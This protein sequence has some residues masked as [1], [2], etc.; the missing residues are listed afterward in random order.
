[1]REHIA[2]MME[3]ACIPDTDWKRVAAAFVVAC[4]V[5]SIDDDLRSALD[6]V[7]RLDPANSDMYRQARR[8]I[9]SATATREGVS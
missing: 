9:D 4:K 6:D 2:E 8:L 1:M 5:H 7:A 3:A